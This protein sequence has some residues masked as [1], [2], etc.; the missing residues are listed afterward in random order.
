MGHKS[1]S[2]RAL[3]RQIAF[4]T[5]LGVKREVVCRTVAT[6]VGVLCFQ[7]DNAS[8]RLQTLVH[9]KNNNQTTKQKNDIYKQTKVPCLCNCDSR[10]V[11]K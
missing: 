6:R 11:G 1:Q 7:C 3:N 10:M 9:V 5:V 8:A 2:H 4:L